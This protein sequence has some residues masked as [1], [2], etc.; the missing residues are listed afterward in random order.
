M[1][2]KILRLIEEYIIEEKFEYDLQEDYLRTGIEFLSGYYSDIVIHPLIENNVIR[3]I[4]MN[5]LKEDPEPRPEFFEALLKINFDSLLGNFSRDLDGKIYLLVDFPI[6][7]KILSK[8][9]FKLC[10]YSIIIIL[11]RYI[12]ILNKIQTTNMPLREIFFSIDGEYE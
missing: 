4:G 7:D 10:L 3:F 6:K 12:P 5:F 1:K 11:E 9:Q 2:R 8:E